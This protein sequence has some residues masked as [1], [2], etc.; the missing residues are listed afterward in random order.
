MSIPVHLHIFRTGRS[1]NSKIA[2]LFSANK[3]DSFTIESSARSNI[4]AEN[5]MLDKMTDFSSDDKVYRLLIKDTSIFDDD[6]H[7]IVIETI[8]NLESIGKNFVKPVG[9]CMLSSCFVDKN[10]ETPINK[11]FSKVGSFTCSQ[12]FLI[13]PDFTLSNDISCLDLFNI[14]NKQ[15]YTIL[16]LSDNKVRFDGTYALSD[17]EIVSRN[18]VYRIDVGNYG[19]DSLIFKF[20]LVVLIVIVAAW[21][22]VQIKKRADIYD[23]K[24]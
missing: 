4:T 7:K 8:K 10:Y 15:E 21:A 3:F 13:T 23:A 22:A 19:R 24:K 16:R 9:I 14:I 11:H 2:S 20:A 18:N 1:G 6:L 5:L 17:S 12:A